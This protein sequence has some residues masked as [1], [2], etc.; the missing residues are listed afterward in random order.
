[1]NTVLPASKRARSWPVNGGGATIGVTPGFP[2]HSIRSLTDGN[3][4][5]AFSSAALS[6]AFF[7]SAL[8]PSGSFEN[9]MGRRAAPG[10]VAA[11]TMPST[12]AA[13]RAK[14]AGGCA[15]ASAISRPI[16]GT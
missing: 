16:A 5:R 7:S 10:P 9:S 8:Q 13:V 1:V 12:S 2:G 3:G 6:S 11:P 15:A 4:A 14:A